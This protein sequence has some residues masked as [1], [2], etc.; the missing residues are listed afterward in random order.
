VN[1]VTEFSSA[2]RNIADP[3][4]EKIL[5]HPFLHETSEGRLPL[6]KFKYYLK[7]DYYYLTAFVRCLG[8][9]VAKDVER[10]QDFSSL[11]HNS[12]TI[13]VEKLECIGQNLGISVEE[14]R[15]VAP[16]PTNVAYTRHLLFIAYAKT[17]GELMAALLP[18][19][20]TYQEIGEMLITYEEVRRHSVYFE[21]C[22]MYASRQYKQ[23]VDWY[24]TIVDH[25]AETSG[26][27]IQDAMRN[28]FL[29][30]SRYEY[31]FWDMAYTKERWSI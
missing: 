12:I 6:D 1:T 30:S 28:H 31:L 20:W 16:A 19:M 29:L 5:Q 26:T 3:I 27:P 22:N 14:L 9:A 18:C 15:N 10:I 2:L 4:W 17:V 24:K 23:L 25:H 8:L 13:E 21:W 7:Q 11:L